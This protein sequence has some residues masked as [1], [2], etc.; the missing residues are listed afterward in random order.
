M[1]K[2]I[3]N[4]IL[5]AAKFYGIKNAH[6]FGVLCEELGICHRR[7]GVWYYTGEKD[8]VGEKLDELLYYLHLK[9]K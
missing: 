5:D 4:N 3:R 2:T 8:M 9:I 6:Q 7:M 1:A